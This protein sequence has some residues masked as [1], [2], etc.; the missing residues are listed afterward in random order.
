MKNIEITS[1]SDWKRVNGELL[2][3]NTI[4]LTL[5]NGALCWLHRP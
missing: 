4:D 5:P 2:E 3:K 1:T